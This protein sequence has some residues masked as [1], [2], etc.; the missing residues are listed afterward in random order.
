VPY[1]KMKNW[2][3]LFARTGSEEKLRDTLKAS[4]NAHEYLPFV[5]V[6]ETPFRIKD[7]MRK[8]WNPVASGWNGH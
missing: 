5:P 7:V 3:I 6:K 1:E 4:P 2:V 8:V